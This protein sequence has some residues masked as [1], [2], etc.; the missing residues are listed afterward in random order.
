MYDDETM[1][2]FELELVKHREPHHELVNSVLQFSETIDIDSAK[3]YL[4]HGIARRLKV[5]SRCI[6]NIFR[7]FPCDATMPISRDAISDVDINLHAFLINTFGVLDDLAWANI[8]IHNQTVPSRSKV[9]LFLKNARERFEA[10]FW[11]RVVDDEIKKWH[12][13]Y[14]KNMRDALAHRIP[15]YVPLFTVSENDADDYKELDSKISELSL[16][17]PRPRPERGAPFEEF[18]RHNKAVD[19]HIAKIEK[20]REQQEALQRPEFRFTHS[21]REDGGCYSF[22]HP[23]ILSDFVNVEKIILGYIEIYNERR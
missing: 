11:D 23:Q 10:D 8:F 19:L 6:L 1:A 21:L 13:D 9:G 4:N 12:T 5:M 15:P 14:Q 18:D 22:I 2:R 17:F 3:E 16:Y 7:K 20:L